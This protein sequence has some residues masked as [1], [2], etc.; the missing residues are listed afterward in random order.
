MHTA[1][2]RC[3]LNDS[4]PRFPLSQHSPLL[5]FTMFLTA[6]AE[7]SPGKLELWQADLL[8][9]GSFDKCFVGE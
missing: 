1:D 6:L 7:G 9:E 4:S 2:T 3:H 8:V 5:P